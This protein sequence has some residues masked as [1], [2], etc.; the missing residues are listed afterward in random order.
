MRKYFSTAKTPLARIIQKAF[1]IAI[2]ANKNNIATNEASDILHSNN[3]NRRHFL[4]DSIKGALALTAGNVLLQ[5]CTKTIDHFEQLEEN[6]ATNLFGRKAPSV[7]IVGAGMAGLHCALLLKDKGINATMYEANNRTGGR[8]YTAPGIMAAGLTT[9]MGG[10]F[11]DSIHKDMFRLAKRYNL[12]LLDV[13]SPANNGLIKDAYFFNG[14]HYTEQDVINAF[15]PIAATMQADIDKLPNNIT[16][17]NPG[18]ALP[19]DFISLEQYINN[20]NCAAWLKSFLKVAFVTEYGLDAGE[21][22]CIN[23]LYLISTDTSAGKFNV[24]GESDERYKIAGGNQQLTNKMTQ[25]LNQQIQYEH[26]LEAINKNSSGKYVLSFRRSN[27]TTVDVTADYVV[28]TIPFSILRKVTFGFSLPAWKRNAIDNLGYGT[29]AKLMLG[30]QNRPWRNLGY[31]GYIFTDA[32]FQNGW[33]NSELQS[34][35]S[36]GFTMYFG[37]TP[38]V[39]MGNGSALSQAAIH[40]PNLNAA[41]PGTQS[42]WNGNAVRFH[43]PTAP[44]VK[45]SYACYK[46]GQFSTIAGAERKTVDRLYFAGEHCSVDYQGYM[47]GA[48]ETGRKAAEELLNV[49]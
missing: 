7:V 5:S 11:I 30:F 44:F 35:S 6:K 4:K 18:A 14:Q 45:G 16:Y 13:E 2:F 22:S 15:A 37:G 36:G 34:P 47:N 33:D 8:I 43:W 12:S 46:T 19:F 3:A 49:L 38:G 10:E 39:Q 31:R 21:Q 24:F 41:F 1:K 48:A 42:K 40:L 29:N 27:Q 26:Q 20:L 23:M 17:N 25:S 28:L 9:E 32:S